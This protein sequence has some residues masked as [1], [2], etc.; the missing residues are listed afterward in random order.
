MQGATAEIVNISRGPDLEYDAD[1]L[2]STGR[3]RNDTKWKNSRVRWSALVGQLSNSRKTEE[4]HAEFMR[5]TKDEQDRIKDIGGFVGGHLKG[6]RRTKANVAARQ[7]VTLDADYAPRDFWSR[8]EDLTLDGLDCACLVYSTHKHT[9]R[10]PRL[11]LVIPLSHEVGPE[12]YEAIA[13]KLAESIGID[14][15]DD[16]TYETNRLMFWP[17]HSSDVAP[18]FELHDAPFLEPEEVLKRYRDWTDAAEW[19]YSSRAKEARRKKAEKVED[20]LTKKGIVGAFCRTYSITEAIRKFLPDVYLPTDKD[21]RWTYAAGSTHGGLVVYDNDTLA[22]SHHSTD[23]ASGLDVNAFDL[24]RLHKFGDLDEGVEGRNG[25]E[26]PSYKAMAEFAVADDEVAVTVASENTTK[27]KDDFGAPA[28][29]DERDHTKW[30]LQFHKVSA[31]GIP[32][33][34][35]DLNIVDYVKSQE[36]IILPAGEPYVYQNGVYV[37]DKGGAN[38][39]NIIKSC[40]FRDLGTIARIER[41]YKLLLID[42]DLQHDT[43]DLN[44]HPKSWVN[45]RNGMLDLK[46]LELH[47]HR[48]EYYNLNQVPFQYDPNYQAPADSITAE[49][50]EA[51]IPNEDDRQMFLEYAG[52]CLSTYMGFQKYLILTGVGGVGKSVLLSMVEGIVGRDN[53]SALK[54]QDIS[55]RFNSRFLYGKL[56]NSC[57]DLSSEAMADTSILKMLVGEDQIPAEIKGGDVF[58]FKPYVKLLFSANRIPVT[59]DEQSNAFYRRLMI[60]P[61]EQAKKHFENLKERLEKDRATFF[62]MA[63]HAAHDAFVRGMLFESGNSLVEVDELHDR[64]DTVTA[65]IHAL[66]ETEQGARMKT[67]EAYEAYEQYCTA[68]ERPALSRTGFR[69]NMKEK[70]YGI[71]KRDGVDVFKNIHLK[72]GSA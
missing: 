35:I 19:P 17:S 8:V 15:F 7:I 53:I 4:T 26:A 39:K 11:R 30:L 67:S 50:L 68:N 18:A 12:E 42:L 36:R 32:V 9:D 70:G 48:P 58:S 29:E 47:E 45:C 63:V 6:G 44:Q 56:L 66:V 23:P 69:S 24:V 37:Y 40:M 25:K 16:T 28:D 46:T 65:F 5:M 52:Y 51:A 2:I 72:S 20:P 49:Y 3:N 14:Y 54:L 1:L 43:D 41:V 62:H 59:R 10:N 61:V 34:I 33:D 38:L 64:A 22:F 57:G 55:G 27:A 71:V 60:L 21:D 31:R 13:R